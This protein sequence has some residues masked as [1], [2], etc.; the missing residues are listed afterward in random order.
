MPLAGS[1]LRSERFV[2]RVEVDSRC[3]KI[4]Q[5]QFHADGSIFV[6]FPYFQHTTGIVS[7]A[8]LP[9]SSSPTT[10]IQLEPGGKISSHLVKYSHHPDGRVLFSQTGRVISLIKKQGVPLA[11][12]DGHLFTVHAEG[13]RRFGEPVPK[14]DRDRQPNPKRTT[15][16]FRFEGQSPD[17]VK[18]VGSL[19]S[20]ESL[21]R[22]VPSGV[23]KP[24]MNTLSPEGR[25]GSTFVCSSPDGTPGQDRFLLL[26]CEP[27]PRLDQARESSLVFL[28]GFDA[29]AVV[30][31]RSRPTTALAFSYPIPNA[32]ELRQRIGS[33]DFLRES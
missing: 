17:S 23:V 11:D 31:D 3:W 30:N 25:I 1:V 21:G 28:G 20:A 16:S 6:N 26:S 8:T 19:H 15:L 22:R 7:L 29:P 27:L 12:V 32:A 2:V 18:F 5:V 24:T 13:L 14:D 4:L 10:E 33:I 9:A